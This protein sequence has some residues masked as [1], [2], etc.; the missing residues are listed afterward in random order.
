MKIKKIL[1][2][3]G[4]KFYWSSRDLHTE[5]GVVKEKDI[6]AHNKVKSNLK[7]EFFVL[8]A[9]LRDNFEKLKR[10]PAVMLPKDIGLILTLTGITK[11]SEVLEAGSGSAFLTSSLA[12]FCKKLYSYESNKAFYHLTQTNIESLDLR[13]VAL[14]HQDIAKGIKERNLDLAVLDLL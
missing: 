11:E 1:Y 5:F 3:E 12:N 13:N 9:Y 10:G 14:K 7:K 4:H 2:H 8:P 6:L